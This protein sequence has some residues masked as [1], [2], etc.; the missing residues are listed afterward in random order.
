MSSRNGA[1]DSTP[2]VPIKKRCVEE[3]VPFVYQ[4][5]LDFIKNSPA[6][7]VSEHL[8]HMSNPAKILE[9]EKLQAA[10]EEKIGPITNFA[11]VNS[12]QTA[13]C[14]YIMDTMDINKAVEDPKVNPITLLDHLL[15]K[16]FV[17]IM[18]V[19]KLFERG[20]DI[21]GSPLFD[22][23]LFRKTVLQDSV[24]V[25]LLIE[26]GADIFKVIPDAS[27]NNDVCAFAAFRCGAWTAL[28]TILNVAAAEATKKDGRRFVVNMKRKD[29]DK[30]DEVMVVDWLLEKRQKDANDIVFASEYFK[31]IQMAYKPATIFHAPDSDYGILHKWILRGDPYFLEIFMEKNRP[32]LEKELKFDLSSKNKGYTALHIAA[33][34]PDDAKILTLVLELMAS[35][36]DVSREVDVP[37]PPPHQF[38][39]LYLAAMNGKAEMVRVL[40]KKGADVANNPAIKTTY[41]PILN[42][43]TIK[44]HVDI[45]DAILGE[46]STKKRA[47]AAVYMRGTGCTLWIT[48]TLSIRTIRHTAP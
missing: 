38:T 28:L 23:I 5:L 41:P 30:V 31:K 7:A 32:L 42:I 10:I 34:Y 3:D 9:H 19:R 12:N 27:G 26:K 1:P 16:T 21:K 13:W 17:P 33:C 35:C 40:L 24:L 43:A 11:L 36:R 25:G 15:K 8:V 18:H 29:S 2:P 14:E 37:G 4:L 20:I 39:P 6:D 47:F 45:V 46:Y 44:G 48:S 22:K